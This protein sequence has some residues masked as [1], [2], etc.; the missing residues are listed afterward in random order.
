MCQST[1][2]IVHEKIYKSFDNCLSLEARS[3][4]LD[5]SKAFDRVWHKG[6]IYKLKTKSVSDN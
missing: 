1:L 3:E 2:S 5:M 4:Y 6:L